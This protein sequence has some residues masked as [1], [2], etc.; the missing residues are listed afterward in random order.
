MPDRPLRIVFAGTPE[1]AAHHLDALITQASPTTFEITAV[2]TQPDRR[3]G[4]GKT[5][6]PSPVK[7]LAEQ[8]RLAIHQPGS[9]R[10]PEAQALLEALAPDVMVVVAYGL[11]LPPIVLKLPRFGC[12]NVHASLLPR[13]RGAAPIERAMLA[14]VKRE[15]SG[16]RNVAV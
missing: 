1:F 2:L 5:L 8:H 6:T 14:A 11:L 15:H 7:Q 10:D 9:L 12:L 16:S 4:R 13:W 3:A